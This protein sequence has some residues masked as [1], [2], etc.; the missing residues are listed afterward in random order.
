MPIDHFD[1]RPNTKLRTLRLICHD[2]LM[3]H[4]PLILRTLE[5]QLQS[6]QSAHLQR[7]SFDFQMNVDTLV[8]LGPFPD[9]LDPSSVHK[10]QNGEMLLRV[11]EL[12]IHLSIVPGSP[13]VCE[14][15][16]PLHED[17]S[18]TRELVEKTAAAGLRTI[19]APFDAR[20][21][22]RI[23]TEVYEGETTSKFYSGASS[24]PLSVEDNV[25]LA[26][27]SSAGVPEEPPSHVLIGQ[28]A[29]TVEA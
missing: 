14:R 16:S 24:T 12:G 22:L 27:A 4:W 2:P 11:S 13:P 20:G 21:A 7:V 15:S 26:D 9:S 17:P 29:R 18:S 6:L 8:R 25:S 1:F 5:D 3:M 19:F 23:T 10:E 28:L